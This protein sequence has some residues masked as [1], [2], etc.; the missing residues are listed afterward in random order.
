MVKQLSIF[1]NNSCDSE[2]AHWVL[3]IDGA[4]RGNPGLAGAGIFL[5]KDNK[6]IAKNSYFLGTKTNNQAEYYA[7]V[8]GLRVLRENMPRVKDQV[9]IYSDSELL[10]RQVKGIYKIK[11]Q[12]LRNL[13]DDAIALLS[14]IEY[15]IEH[16]R[17][18][19]NTVADDLANKAFD[20]KLPNQP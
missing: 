2:K 7:L 1:Q 13:Y 20:K 8:Y 12:D 15:K 16:V 6:V 18:E 19:K 5:S 3:Y 17:R 14:G 4:S 11:N 10:V 9:T